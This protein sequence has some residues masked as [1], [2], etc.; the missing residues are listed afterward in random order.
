V[1]SL[2][3]KFAVVNFEGIVIEDREKVV[4][5]L[6]GKEIIEIFPEQTEKFYCANIL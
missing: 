2:G 6:K 5:A 1:L 3:E 4:K